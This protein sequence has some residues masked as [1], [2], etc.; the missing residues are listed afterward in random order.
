MRWDG[1]GGQLPAFSSPSPGLNTLS[2]DMDERCSSDSRV[3]F[4]CD[5]DMGGEEEREM[6]CQSPGTPGEQ[7]LTRQA[8]ADERRWMRGSSPES[9]SV[10]PRPPETR[11]G[12]ENRYTWTCMISVCYHDSICER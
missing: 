12:L 5:H 11:L 1:R 7:T 6:A 3:T 9:L 4:G 10:D 2:E 8:E